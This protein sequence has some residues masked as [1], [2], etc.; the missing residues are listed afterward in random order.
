MIYCF[1]LFQAWKDSF[2]VN[3]AKRFE[4]NIGRRHDQEIWYYEQML[5]FALSFFA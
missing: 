5:L 1:I 3:M 2:G 4:E